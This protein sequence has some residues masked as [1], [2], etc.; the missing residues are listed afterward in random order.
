MQRRPFI[1]L[2][3]ASAITPHVFAQQLVG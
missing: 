3:G 1:A 2:A